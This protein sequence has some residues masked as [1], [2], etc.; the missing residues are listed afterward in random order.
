MI[1]REHPNY[2][3]EQVAGHLADALA[4]VGELEL[5]DELAPIAFAK[6]VD[7]LAAKRI[8]LE[9]AGILGGHLA[10]LRPQ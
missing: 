1:A 2:T 4:I 3:R 8:E 5:T 9:Q 6:A 7:L 10:A